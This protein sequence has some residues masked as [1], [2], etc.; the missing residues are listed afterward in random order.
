[1]ATWL[2]VLTPRRI[3]KT[4]LEECRRCIKK[5]GRA[6]QRALFFKPGS[7]VSAAEAGREPEIYVEILVFTVAVGADFPLLDRG[8]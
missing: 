6:E 1:M 3:R 8:V 5:R 7:G 2:S 4:E